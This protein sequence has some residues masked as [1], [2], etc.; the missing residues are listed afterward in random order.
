MLAVDQWSACCVN[1]QPV[2]IPDIRT[3]VDNQMISTSTK[4]SGRDSG[5]QVAV[6]R[7]P[8]S[9]IFFPHERFL[10][11]LGRRQSELAIKDR[12]GD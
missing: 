11:W 1:I 9:K 12:T 5:F 6:W 10:Q 4:L 8:E 2:E 3:V 7:G